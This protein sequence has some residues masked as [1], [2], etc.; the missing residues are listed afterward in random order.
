MPL[1]PLQTILLTRNSKLLKHC[2]QVHLK[3][4][5]IFFL[6]NYQRNGHFV[7]L[8]CEET[9]S[10]RTVKRSEKCSIRNPEFYEWN[11]DYTRHCRCTT[12]QRLLSLEFFGIKN[13][14]VFATDKLILSKTVKRTG[15]VSFKNGFIS[16]TVTRE[17]QIIFYV[18]S[19]IAFPNCLV[20]K[21]FFY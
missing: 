13:R 15:R 12:R 18:W 11:F 6:K 14:T 20:T 16:P 3:A 1:K 9:S 10:I 7:L 19:E 2:L 17:S 8:F 5:W 4:S 21:R